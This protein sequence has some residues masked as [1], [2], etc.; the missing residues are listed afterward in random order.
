MMQGHAMARW[1]PISFKESEVGMVKVENLS[2]NN[3][4]WLFENFR[5]SKVVEE[6]DSEE[7]QKE[8]AMACGRF[9]VS[10]T[11]GL[12]MATAWCCLSRKLC[13]ELL[14]WFCGRSI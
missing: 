8:R 9:V 12:F 11:A 3:N 7:I 4:I 1:F 5:S 6:T 13:P 2:M 10:D 14:L